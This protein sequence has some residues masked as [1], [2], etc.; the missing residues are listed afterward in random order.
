MA[1]V[2][3]THGEDL[4]SITIGEVKGSHVKLRFR[5]EPHAFTLTWDPEGELF[6]VEDKQLD[7]HVYAPTR[8]ELISQLVEQI[9]FL[10]LE[11][12]DTFDELTPGAAELGHRLRQLLEYVEEA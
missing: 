3:E 12:V 6:V 5:Q 1:D 9:E 8:R 2:Y 11:Y 10:W 4:S 7:I